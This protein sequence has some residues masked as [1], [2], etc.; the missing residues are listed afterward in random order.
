[1]RSSMME[2]ANLISHFEHLLGPIRSLFAG[3]LAGTALG[4]TC[5]SA[6]DIEPRAYSNIPS[7]INFL[8]VGYGYSEGNVTF[9]PSVPITNGKLT[10]D[11]SVFAY[12]RSLDLWGKSGKFDII[13]PEVWLSGTAKVLGQTRSR[14]VFGLADPIFRFYVNLFGAPSLSLKEFTEYKQD[15]I[16]GVS[17]EVT[18]P[19]GQ[20]DS[21]KLVNIGTNR[22]SFKPEIGISKVFGP[23][24]VELAGGAYF[25]TDNNQP[26]RGN[27][28]QQ[29]PIYAVQG[30]L[31]RSF[32]RGI[33][34]ALDAIYYFGGQTTQDGVTSDNS[35]E[36]L[37][38]GATFTFP[39]DRKNSVKLYGNTGVY[40]RTRSNFNVIGISWQYSWG[41]GL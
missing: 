6:A 30:H 1:M 24:T 2:S 31:I 37:R 25:F 15:T 16:I 35:Q 34:G 20:Y 8:I 33:W 23:L 10:T 26:F 36:N 38:F 7:G 29:A 3:M 18:A 39:I 9:D 12:S 32:G 40:S 4:A 28:L 14:A 19:L 27:N 22:W 13:I 21:Q 41:G 11:S 17:L 5:L